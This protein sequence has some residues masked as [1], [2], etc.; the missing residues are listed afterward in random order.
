MFWTNSQILI[1][2]G[3]VFQL[4]S[5]LYQARKVFHPF[6]SM[7]DKKMDY[8]Q[9]EGER[10]SQRIKEDDRTWF[11]TIMLI[12]IGLVFQGLAEFVR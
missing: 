2:I 10:I 7:E 4:M 12:F 8:V 11:W 3:L 6:K 5:V 1:V 9:R